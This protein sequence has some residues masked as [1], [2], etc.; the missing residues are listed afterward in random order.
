[1]NPEEKRLLEE[2]AALA[3]ENHQ[4]LKRMQRAR[5]WSRF[6]WLLKW[7]IIIGVTVWL[8]YY[9]QPIINQL[10]KTYE[11]LTTLNLP[12]LPNL[13]DISKLLGGGR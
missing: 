8:Y 12:Q 5:R 9:L 4:I 7:L 13:G 1:M 6:F 3:R 10:F 11:S 2:V